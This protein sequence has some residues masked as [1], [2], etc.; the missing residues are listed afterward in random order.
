MVLG[1]NRSPWYI[2]VDSDIL[3]HRRSDLPPA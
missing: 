1:V 2:G 3:Q